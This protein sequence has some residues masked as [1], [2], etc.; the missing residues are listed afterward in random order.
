MKRNL[1]IF[2]LL[3][4]CMAIGAQTVFKNEEVEVSLLKE[5][6]WVFSTWDYTTMYLIEGE[7]KAVLIDTGTRC[8]DLDKIVGQITGKPLE[9]AWMPGHTPGSVVLLDKANGDCYSGD[10]FGSGEVWLQCVPMSPI[11][12]F[13]ESCCRMEKLMKEGHIKD[14]WCG[15]YPYLKSSLPLAYIQ[16][17]IRISH[18]LMNGDQEGSEPYS[19]Y[20]IKMPPTARK[21]AE[22]RAM[23]VY[24]S[25]N[26]PEAR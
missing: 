1:V 23:I 15:H 12:T 16:T 3:F 2:A 6:T 17:M 13:H 5:K 22:G 25:T 26:I 20:F 11:A 18:R 24:D 19:N 7:D 9:V 10:A 8:A 14:I 21:L 4:V